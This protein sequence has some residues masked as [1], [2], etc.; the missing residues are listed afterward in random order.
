[1]SKAFTHN[2][3]AFLDSES[4]IIHVTKISTISAMEF[5]WYQ[6]NFGSW[7]ARSIKIIM[8]E[9]WLKC[10]SIEINVTSQMLLSAWSASYRSCHL[11]PGW[12]GLSFSNVREWQVIVT[13]HTQDL[14]FYWETGKS[15]GKRVANSHQCLLSMVH[16]RTPC[17]ALTC[18]WDIHKQPASESVIINWA[19]KRRGALKMMIN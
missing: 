15:V 5:D 6:L 19:L 14:H 17:W 4:A 8:D 16:S 18:I 2:I 1:M 10:R 3:R 11:I 12:L 7:S 9:I 13:A